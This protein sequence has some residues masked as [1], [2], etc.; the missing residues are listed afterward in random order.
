MKKR[1][2]GFVLCLLMVISMIPFSAFASAG[3]A[4]VTITKEPTHAAAAAGKKVKTA[5]KAA[6]EGLKYQWY[7]KNPGAEKFRKSTITSS[8]YSFKMTKA[9]SGRQVY[10]V[11]RDLYGNKVKT[12]TVTL[13]IPKTL[14]ITAQPADVLTDLGTTGKLT[15]KASGDQVAYRWYVKAPGQTKFQKTDEKG[16]TFSLEMTQEALGTQAYCRI[17]DMF[18]NAVKTRTATFAVAKGVFERTLYKIKPGAKRTLALSILPEEKTDEVIFTSSNPKI[19][20]VDEAGVVTGVKKGTVTITARGVNTGFTATCQVKVCD[21]K[22]VA[23]TFDDGPSKYTAELLDALKENDIRVTFF[24]VGNRM[25]TYKTT[26]KREVAEG[27]EIGY[28]SWTHA[29][30]TKLTSSKIASDYKK[31][32][33]TL[34]SI[35]GGEFT[36]WRTPGGAR[37]DRVLQQ[38]DLPHIMWSVDTLDWKYRSSTRTC[39]VIQQSAKDGSIILLHDLHKSTVKGAIKALK[40]MQA[41][42]YE[43]LTVTELLSRKGKTPQNHK[44]YSRG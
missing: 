37:N 33:R 41:G 25:S 9:K 38:I 16:R 40:E 27:H 17:T 36:V 31:A 24:L 23:I 30:Q 6:G 29:F 10:C 34:K 39:K 28:H 4:P 22:Q 44:S 42:D 35:A 5:V 26:V 12:Q 32:A 15:A 18:G 20:Q 8:T 19:A 13:K 14:K 21:V 43:F 7:Y 11:I 1:M 2:L 3:A